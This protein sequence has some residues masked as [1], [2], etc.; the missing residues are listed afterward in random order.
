MKYLIGIDEAGRGPLAGPVSVG[1]IMVPMNFD[2]SLADGA[3]DS[4]KMTE[5]AREELYA[6]IHEMQENGL[7]KYAVSFSAATIIDSRG[8]VPAIK[9]ALKRCLEKLEADPGE[10]E[11][12]LDGSLYAPKQFTSQTT[13]IRGDDS[14]PVISMASIMAK[15]TRDRYMKK[16]ARTYPAYAFD[17]H[18]GYGTS[19]HRLA[20]RSLGLSPLHRKSFCSRVLAGEIEAETEEILQ[21]RGISV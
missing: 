13:I 16:Q 11:I 5:K 20:I 7:L 4:K 6:R 21:N 17:E 3:R 18:V 9:S 19:K 10:C 2:F 14:E 15:V 8:I 12:R 1:A